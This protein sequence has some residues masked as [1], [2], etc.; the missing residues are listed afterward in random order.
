MPTSISDVATGVIDAIAEATSVPAGM[1]EG[2]W[3]L[4]TNLEADSQDFVLMRMKWS[5]RFGVEIYTDADIQSLRTQGLLN[6]ITVD[7]VVDRVKHKLGLM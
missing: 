7:A 1:I 2:S 4:V 6:T 3:S 5:Q